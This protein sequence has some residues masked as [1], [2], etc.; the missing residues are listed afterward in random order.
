MYSPVYHRCASSC[1]RGLDVPGIKWAEDRTQFLSQA[2]GSDVTRALNGD[3]NTAHVSAA[4]PEQPARRA[5][6]GVTGSLLISWVGLGYLMEG[7]W[8]YRGESES[9]ELS[10]I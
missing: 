6:V 3:V 2:R 7:K 5:R 9:P 10:N 8:G 4:A 1:M